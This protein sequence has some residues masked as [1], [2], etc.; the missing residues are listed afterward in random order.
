MIDVAVL[1]GCIQGV[2]RGNHGHVAEVRRFD[3][4]CIAAQLSPSGEGKL[5]ALRIR[6][7]NDHKATSAWNVLV[8]FRT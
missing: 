6:K 3:C 5:G 7:Y 4:R 8:I 2:Q 1:S